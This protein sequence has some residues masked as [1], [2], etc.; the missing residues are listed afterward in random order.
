VWNCDNLASKVAVNG[1]DKKSV[2]ARGTGIFLCATTSTLAL[3]STQPPIR[4]VLIMFQ[5][6][7]V[8]SHLPAC[9][10]IGSS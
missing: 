8:H 4:S 10:V 3:W 2:F 9:N 6:E 5:D 1:L 7:S